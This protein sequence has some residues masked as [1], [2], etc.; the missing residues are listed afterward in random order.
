MGSLVKYEGVKLGGLDG[1]F[2]GRVEPLFEEEGTVYE[3]DQDGEHQETETAVEASAD[4]SKNAGSLRE[5]VELVPSTLG[6]LVFVW[7][8]SFFVHYIERWSTFYVFGY[9]RMNIVGD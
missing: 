2:G 7:G 8:S 9:Y 6:G 5:H 3:G 1:L 4:V